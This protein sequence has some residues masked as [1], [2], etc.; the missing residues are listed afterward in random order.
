MKEL[1][2]TLKGWVEFAEKILVVIT[3]VIGISVSAY[4]GVTF[5]MAKKQETLALTEESLKRKEVLD[6]FSDAYLSQL[7]TINADIRTLD[8][9]LG[10]EVWKN[11]TGW[12]VKFAVRLEKAKDRQEILVT[13]GTQILELKKLE[14][15]Q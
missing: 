15:R 7:E 4:Q 9:Q 3:L 5:L 1:S 6:R 14:G 8:E 13:L 10:K 12:D 2:P 11:T